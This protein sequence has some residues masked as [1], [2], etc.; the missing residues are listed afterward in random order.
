MG[1]GEPVRC[2]GSLRCST[3]RH[4]ALGIGRDL[5]NNF[6]HTSQTLQTARLYITPHTSFQFLPFSSCK[7]HTL[8]KVPIEKSINS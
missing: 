3:W 5:S 1:I 7:S 4:W 8:N 2:G 6:S